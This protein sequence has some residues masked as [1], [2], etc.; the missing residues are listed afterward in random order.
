MVTTDTLY[1]VIRGKGGFKVNYMQSTPM[2]KCS[3]IITIFMYT[4]R[5]TYS[6][7]E[8]VIIAQFECNE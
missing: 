1:I 3:I 7:A 6:K 5:E 2:L 4:S 8:D